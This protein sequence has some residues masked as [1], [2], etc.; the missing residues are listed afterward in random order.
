MQGVTF[1]ALPVRSSSHV[2]LTM[3]GVPLGKC[4]NHNR[5]QPSSPAKA[6]TPMPFEESAGE[7]FPE[8]I[9]LLTAEDT[10]THINIYIYVRFP[11][12]RCR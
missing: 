10:H 12:V 9:A 11:F 8:F 5:T 4:R 1:I 7:T 2:L 3:N 6:Q